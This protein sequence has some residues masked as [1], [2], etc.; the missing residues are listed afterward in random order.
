V[1]ETSEGHAGET[2]AIFGD[3]RI[4]RAGLLQPELTPAPG[5]A[6]VCLD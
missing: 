4:G 5:R 1:F 3:Y 2:V 6:T